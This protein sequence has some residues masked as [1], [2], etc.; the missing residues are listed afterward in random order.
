M[1][2]QGGI[3]L[4]RITSVTSKQREL[5]ADY[6]SYYAEYF[7]GNSD[8]L[9]SYDVNLIGED[10]YHAIS[11]ELHYGTGAKPSDPEFGGPSSIYLEAA[12][13]IQSGWAPGEEVW[14]HGHP[15]GKVS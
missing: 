2:N 9:D 8:C 11:F 14:F 3:T 12:S 1:T 5:A 4:P 13:L 6:C 7:N 10:A 15:T